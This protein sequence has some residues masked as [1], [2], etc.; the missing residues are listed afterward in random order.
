M[1][2]KAG[3]P[4][5]AGNSSN[6]FSMLKE[7]LGFGPEKRSGNGYEVESVCTHCLGMLQGEQ[8]SST[9]ISLCLHKNDPDMWLM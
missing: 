4:S 1:P 6:P 2:R 5:T 8:K 7:E 9:R 3:E